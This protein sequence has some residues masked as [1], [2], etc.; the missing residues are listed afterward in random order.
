MTN[1]NFLLSIYL[2]GGMDGLS[3]LIPYNDSSYT[4]AR[5]ATLIHPP[6]TPNE[7]SA[8]E[9]TDPIGG[10]PALGLHPALLPLQELYDQGLLS[11][12]H[13]TGSL[14]PT[15]SHFN[16][17]FFTEVG[18]IGSSQNQDPKG[19][20]TR[21]MEATVPAVEPVPRAIGLG[22]VL[23]DYL[24]E[25]SKATPVGDAEAFGFPGEQN[26][27]VKRKSLLTTLYS[28][29]QSQLSSQFDTMDQGIDMVT[30]TISSSYTSSSPNHQY[31]SSPLGKEI[32]HAAQFARNPDGPQIVHIDKGGWDTHANQGV[33]GPTNP[34]T[35]YKLFDDLATNVQAFVEDMKTNFQRNT[36]VL[37]MTEFGRS[38]DENVSMGTD[39][40]RGSVAFVAG[41][42]IQI[43]PLSQSSGGMTTG[44]HGK[45]IT[46][47][48][49]FN[50]LVENGDLDVT[51]DIRDI[52]AEL[53]VKRLGLEAP[54]PSSKFADVF[55]S[56][57]YTYNEHGLFD[58]A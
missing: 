23:P 6:Q 45:V 15:R 17:Q 49:G 37:V 2:R 16:Q 58:Q 47:W 26:F 5:T 42:G 8:L 32:S 38:L 39:H 20:W 55:N 27:V 4:G 53:L 35:L 11:F 10:T 3:A 44:G 9:L 40:G 28:N 56:Q 31:T 43:V 52:Q 24:R 1:L 48:P 7:F 22:T 34:G 50:P 25:S 33:Q 46:N 29:P 18:W 13:A 57:D 19:L 21:F 51:I 41:D 14:D 36:T 54:G 12:V 30:S